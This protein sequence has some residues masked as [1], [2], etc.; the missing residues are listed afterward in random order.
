MISQLDNWKENFSRPDKNIVA[1]LISKDNENNDKLYVFVGFRD[2][3][4]MS[5][6]SYSF[7]LMD[8]Q[9]KPKTSY[10]TERDEV[11]KFIPNDIKNKKQIFPIIKNMTRE[12]LDSYLP[13]NISRRTVEPVDG[14]SLKRYEEITNIMINEYG[15]KLV[16]KTVDEFNYTRWKLTRNEITDNNKD[17]KESYEI[18]HCLSTQ[19]LHKSMFDHI[20]PLLKEMDLKPIF[21]GRFPINEV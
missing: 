13:Q 3:K 1:T 20:L 16:D 9:D 7:M 4:D 2:F 18:I 11:S 15:Y 21:T 19:E 8:S 5:E 6:Y 14:D 17:M 10:M 12:L